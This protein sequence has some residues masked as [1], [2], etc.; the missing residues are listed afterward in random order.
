MLWMYDSALYERVTVGNT[1]CCSACGGMPGWAECY[2]GGM[3]YGKNSS[4][5]YVDSCYITTRWFCG[6]RKYA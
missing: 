1:D 5:G 6:L 4:V 2:T 3:S